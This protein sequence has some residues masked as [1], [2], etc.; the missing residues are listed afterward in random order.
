MTE[1]L[2]DVPCALFRAFQC[3]EFAEEFANGKFRMGSL[4][5]YQTTPDAARRDVYEGTAIYRG[6]R[7]VET[8]AVNG[9]VREQYVLCCCS[10]SVDLSFLR[11]K[12]GPYVVRISNPIEFAEMIES[13]L[14]RNGIPTLNGVHGRMVEYTKGLEL[15]IDLSPEE[16]FDLSLR[17]KEPAYRDEC[18]YRIFLILSR[19][20]SHPTGGS[21][22]SIDLGEHPQ[23]VE[24]VR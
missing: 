12:M 22:L 4:S 20:A 3:L 17:Q 16:N 21:Y 11:E 18:E 5:S 1:K 9:N 7:G 8:T 6:K 14:E 19:R 10:E 13:S 24:L 15:E 2:R 23:C